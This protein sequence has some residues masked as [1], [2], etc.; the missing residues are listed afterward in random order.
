MEQPD[1]EMLVGEEELV[2]A[3]TDMSA[4]VNESE[5]LYKQ[6]V[7]L[8]SCRVQGVT[9][10]NDRAEVT[11]LIALTDLE[12]GAVSFLFFSFL[13]FYAMILI[14]IYFCFYLFMQER[15]RCGWW[16]CRRRW[17]AT[18]CGCRGARARP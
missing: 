4:S 9:V 18:R 17:T 2:G 6:T 12:A 10:Y 5:Q 11:R 13:L 8:A 16:G 15:R 14:F 3:D 1:K 7:P